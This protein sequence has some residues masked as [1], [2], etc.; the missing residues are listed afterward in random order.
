MNIG[1]KLIRMVTADDDL[2]FRQGVADGPQLRFAMLFLLGICIPLGGCHQ[3]AKHDVDPII[4]F[5][6]VPQWSNGDRNE[7]DV[8]EGTV[9]GARQGQRMVLYSKCGGLWWLQPLVGSPFTAI[10]P[11]KQWR[12]EVYL[13]TDYAALLVDAAYHPA[14][15]LRSLPDRGGT[16]AQVASAHGPEKSSSFFV[17]FSGFKWRLRWKPSNRGG[18]NNPYSADNV[19]TDQSGALHLGI[20]KRDERWTCSEASLTRS[21]GYGTYSFIVEDVSAMDPGVVF[22]IFTW[23]YS[24]GQQYNS[25]FDLNISQW[26][27]PDSSNAEFTLQPTYLPSNV[28]RFS[29]PAGKLKHTIVWEPGKITMS[30]SPLSNEARVISSHVFQSQIPKPGLESVRMTFYVYGNPGR[31]SSALQ[32]PTEVVVDQFQYLP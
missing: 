22:G 14:A 7:H 4:S 28:S 9:T 13:G 8:I 24:S 21:L 3:N 5:T 12:N 31:K 20:I 26:G 27:D 32:R 29:A 19:Y 11:D 18:T 15:V 17:D 30:T 10:L 25:E 6:Q 1:P 23:D 2:R 16:V